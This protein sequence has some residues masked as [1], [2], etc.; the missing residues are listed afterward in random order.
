M[1]FCWAASPL[2]VLLLTVV[3]EGALPAEVAA[4]VEDVLLSVWSDE[5]S[6][7]SVPLKHHQQYTGHS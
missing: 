3:D 5:F 1:M 2:P 4:G 7:T 6:I